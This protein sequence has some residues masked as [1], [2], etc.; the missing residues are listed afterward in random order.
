M[1]ASSSEIGRCRVAQA[2]LESRLEAKNVAKLFDEGPG[3]A[4]ASA[5]RERWLIAA[6]YG[7][8]RGMP[9]HNQ[10]MDASKVRHFVGS[11]RD[12]IKP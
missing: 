9:R 3:L 5:W 8:G 7:S 2:W 4:H 6:S 1:S 12:S 10:L 11:A